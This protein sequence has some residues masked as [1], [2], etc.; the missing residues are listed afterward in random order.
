MG[1]SLQIENPKKSVFDDDE[2]DCPAGWMLLLE[3]D[4]ATK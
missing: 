4:Q 2:R 1:R 3:P